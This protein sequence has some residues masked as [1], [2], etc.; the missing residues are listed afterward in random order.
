MTY[1]SK[2]C[3]SSV[4]KLHLHLHIFFEMCARMRLSNS[5]ATRQSD[6]VVFYLSLVTVFFF[7][8]LCPPIDVLGDADNN[9]VKNLIGNFLAHH[10]LIEKR[11]SSSQ[12][13]V[14]RGNRVEPRDFTAFDDDDPL[15]GTRNGWPSRADNR[16]CP[17][18]TFVEWFRADDL[19]Y[20][21]QWP[22]R[23]GGHRAGVGTAGTAV[24][25]R[26]PLQCVRPSDGDAVLMTVAERRIAPRSGTNNPSADIDRVTTAIS[27][28]QQYGCRTR[29]RT[30]WFDSAGTYWMMEK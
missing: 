23:I 4:T 9:S 22:P 18:V 11:I 8:S 20:R 29:W 1:I 19:G 30:K 26:R 14:T 3:T 17:C 15:R 25:R 5:F 21:A 24:C 2:S 12:S 16:R 28:G 27:G 13:C 7:D 6:A 10:A